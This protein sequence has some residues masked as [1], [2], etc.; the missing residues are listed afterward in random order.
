[1]RVPRHRDREDLRIVIA[2]IGASQ[3]AD[4][5]TGTGDR[6]RRSANRVLSKSAIE[7]RQNADRIRSEYAASY[8]L[9]TPS[10]VNTPCKGSADT[11]W[12]HFNARRYVPNPTTWWQAD[13]LWNTDKTSERPGGSGATST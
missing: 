12:G 7:R 13:C 3:T 4:P 2:R 9:S 6:M 5:I 11:Y 8:S 1:M 10:R